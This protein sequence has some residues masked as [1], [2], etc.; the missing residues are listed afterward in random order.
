MFSKWEEWWKK[1]KRR[2]E[3]R[4][5]HAQVSITGITKG[6]ATFT[7]KLR[8]LCLGEKDDALSSRTNITQSQSE[9]AHKL[10]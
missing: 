6:G 9:Q 5:V 3:K 8:M 4:D 1:E 10:A 7:K 2:N